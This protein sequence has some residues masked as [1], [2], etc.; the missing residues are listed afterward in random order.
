MSSWSLPASTS[1]QMA[2]SVS[3][4]PFNLCISP[5]FVPAPC[6]WADWSQSCRRK[7][8]PATLEWRESTSTK[9][10]ECDVRS[11]KHCHNTAAGVLLVSQS[12]LLIYCAKVRFVSPHFQHSHGHLGTPL[13][14]TPLPLLPLPQSPH[15]GCDL[16]VT[17]RRLSQSGIHDNILS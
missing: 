7:S 1:A 5:I 8:G 6:Q 3:V 2:S 12:A 4:W 16:N 13:L 17:E 10:Y 9:V 15:S 11:S 14:S